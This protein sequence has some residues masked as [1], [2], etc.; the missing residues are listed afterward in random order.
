MSTFYDQKIIW[1]TG[2][3]SGIGLGLVKVL[4]KQ[5]C[6]LIISGR[7]E[8]ELQKIK[9]EYE[10]ELKREKGKGVS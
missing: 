5:S 10:K 4:S 3:S 9:Q 6:T 7:Q 1:I 8:V 2:A